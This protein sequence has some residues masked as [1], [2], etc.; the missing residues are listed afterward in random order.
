MTRRRRVHGRSLART[1][2]V[3][4]AVLIGLVAAAPA[5]AA[6][7]KP[8]VVLVHGAW[9][10]TSG[11]DGVASRLRADGYPVVVPGNPL[12]SVSGDAAAIA[13][14]VN[15]IAGPVVLVGH[16]YGGMVI[17]NAARSTPNVKALVYIAAFAPEQGESAFQLNTKDLGSL[18]APGLV[19]VP[20]LGPGLKVG[21]NLFLN[22]L[23]FP[24]V[25]AQDV[26][27]SMAL[28]MAVAQHP[29]TLAA[30]SER[31]GPPAWRQLP[32]W[33]MVAGQDRVIPPATERFMAQRAGSHTVE[34]AGS[35]V[36]FISHPDAAAQLIRD[37]ATAT[38][39]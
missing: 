19:P 31:S 27:V 13:G 22:P 33:Y 4:A 32:S 9:A 10:D 6:G 35:H 18:A 14:V 20:F 2:A 26:P 23:F 1:F 39:P 16:S 34:V 21:V 3:A 15:A 29:V 28:A 36:V 37:A 7:P 17:T 8:T 38:A 5:T 12:R 30:V 25:F 24:T 11:W